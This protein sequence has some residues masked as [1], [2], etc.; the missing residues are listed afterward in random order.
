MLHVLCPILLVPLP[1][2]AVFDP[3]KAVI[4][5][6]LTL[7]FTVYFSISITCLGPT[8]FVRQPTCH[9]SATESQYKDHH[10]R[11]CAKTS[12][13]FTLS[14]ALA[15]RYMFSNPVIK[16]GNM[17]PIVKMEKKHAKIAAP[18]K[19]KKFLNVSDMLSLKHHTM[20][21]VC[22]FSIFIPF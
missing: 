19:A 16:Q 9:A 8:P 21:R 4:G 13:A 12:V 3:K 5:P 11:L 18:K 14:P 10:L 6:Y 17:K 1:K 22:C 15:R 7:F 2:N 20:L